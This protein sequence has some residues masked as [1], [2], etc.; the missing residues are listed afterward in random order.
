MRRGLL[1]LGVLAMAGLSFA[2]AKGRQ[3]AEIRAAERGRKA[4]YE[5]CYNPPIV[6][7]KAY[8][9]AWKQWGVKDKP[10]D[11]DRA[12]RDRY[13]LSIAPYANAG[14]PLGLRTGNGPLGKGLG[15]DC[16]LCHA[17]SIAGQTVIGLGNASVDVQSLSEDLAAAGGIKGLLPFSVSNVR[18]T[19]EAEAAILY[20]MQFR[21][22]DLNVQLPITLRYRTTLCEDIPAWWHLKKK[23][24]MFHTGNI[25]TRSI[26]ANMPFLLSP[27]NSAAFIKQQEPVFRD[28][29]AFLLTLEAP[30]YPFAVDNTKAAQGKKLFVQ[31]CAK[32]HGTYGPSGKYPNKVV[33]L[34][35]IGTDPTLIA[36]Y[37]AKSWE[38]YK[39]SWFNQERGPDGKPYFAEESRGYQAPPL[40]GI[41]ATAPYFHNGSVPTVYHVL[42]SRARPKIHTRSFRTAREDY[43]PVKLGWKITV[44]PKGPDPKLPP[45]E[46][47]KI[48]DTRQ[49]GRGNGGHTF[50]DKLTEAERM[51][52]IEYLKT[53]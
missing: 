37:S 5:R 4:L 36:G 53:L 27:F 42:N 39:K 29:R 17:G 52:V 22:A 40:D 38:H 2:L 11:Y 33:A 13:G 24:T 3:P 15:N 34:D 18:G 20:L 44:L 25:D 49:P 50:G 47:R 28:I 19:I 35:V 43:D 41:W 1:C 8:D 7:L 23:K 30:R 32:C 48:Y 21:D 31:N 45:F 12:F 16:L 14:L 26:R 46:R 10:A 51:T 9:N 6:S